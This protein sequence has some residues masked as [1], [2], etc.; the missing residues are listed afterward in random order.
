MVF[1]LR[2][3]LYYSSVY[4]IIIRNKKKHLA[5]LTSSMSSK[6]HIGKKMLLM[7]ETTEGIEEL[8]RSLDFM[9]PKYR[10]LPPNNTQSTPFFKTSYKL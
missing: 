4:K 1:L 7:G 8:T 10:W 6:I 9:H 5:D 2:F 3:H